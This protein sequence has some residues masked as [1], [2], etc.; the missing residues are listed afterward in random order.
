MNALDQQASLLL[1][2]VIMTFGILMMSQPWSEVKLVSSSSVS[3][4]ALWNQVGSVS[5]SGP[6]ECV[7]LAWMSNLGLHAQSVSLAQFCAPQIDDNQLANTTAP[8]NVSYWKGQLR[9][10]APAMWLSSDPLVCR[11]S[12]WLTSIALLCWTV[13][14]LMRVFAGFSN[15]SIRRQQ[16]QNS[17]RVMETTVVPLVLWWIGCLAAIAV[18]TN[19]QSGCVDTWRRGLLLPANTTDGDI[20]VTQTNVYVLA[21]VFT[22]L[23]NLAG[24][25]ATCLACRALST[26]TR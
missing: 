13:G 11:S 1:A 2:A 17:N 22:C 15:G 9:V 16:Q 8:A 26:R 14:L 7:P 5:L 12:F 25:V 20:N 21:I 6:T 3:Y 10:C 4:P 18:V 19:W 23:A 24:L